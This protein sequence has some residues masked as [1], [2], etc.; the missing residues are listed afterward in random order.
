MSEMKYCFLSKR[1][2]YIVHL[3]SD[4]EERI[5]GRKVFPPPVPLMLSRL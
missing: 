4:F 5:I 1:D 2:S 3:A